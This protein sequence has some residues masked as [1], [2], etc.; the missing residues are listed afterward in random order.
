MGKMENVFR[1]TKCFGCFTG[2][3]KYN[4]SFPNG[5]MKWVIKQGWYGKERVYLC[6]GKIDDQEAIRVDTNPKVKPTH[7]EDARKTSL[8]NE[9][10]DWIMIDPPYTKEL[11]KKLY[12]MEEYYSGINVFT[13]EAE[14]ICKVGGLILTLTY[15]IPKRI[16]NCEFVDVCGIYTIPSTSYMRCFTVSK[17]TQNTIISR[18]GD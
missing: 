18:G 17:K 13:K 11:A 2:K 9:S 15:E 7:L 3:D 4:G 12:N 1:T 6:S 10:A 8:P 5:F 14:R 16:K